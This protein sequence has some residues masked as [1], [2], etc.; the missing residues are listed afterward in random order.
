MQT[1]RNILL[2]LVMKEQGS[3]LSAYDQS[4]GSCVI[5]ASTQQ[6]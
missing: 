2:D 5:A 6:V 1:T 3:S 4:G